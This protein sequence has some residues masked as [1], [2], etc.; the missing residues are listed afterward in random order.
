MKGY[1]QRLIALYAGTVLLGSLFQSFI[2]LPDSIL[3]NKH[4]VLNRLF[5]K[6]GWVR[7]L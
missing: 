5:V 3:S 6:M 2:P 4:N 7:N 1:Q